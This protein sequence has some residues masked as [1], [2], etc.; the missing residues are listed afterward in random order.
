[1]TLY[2]AWEGVLLGLELSRGLEP[3]RLVELREEIDAMHALEGVHRLI[4][5]SRPSMRGVERG[6]LALERLAA[7]L[8]EASEPPVL[9][10][11][12]R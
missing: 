1:M 12:A 4:W 7:V 8:L 6:A 3:S 2:R 10:A 5:L 11:V 9:Y